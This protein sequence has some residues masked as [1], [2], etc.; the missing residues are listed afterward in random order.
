LPF[1]LPGWEHPH[2]AGLGGRSKEVAEG[3][4]GSRSDSPGKFLE[5]LS[6]LGAYVQAGREFEVDAVRLAGTRLYGDRERAW[7]GVRPGWAV[8]AGDQAE[9]DGERERGKRRLRAGGA[10]GD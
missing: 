8:Q 1:P 4:L 9:S 10:A 3:G 7:R 2:C 6:I 5:M